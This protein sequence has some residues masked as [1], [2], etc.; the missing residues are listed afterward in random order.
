MNVD[1]SDPFTY[2]LLIQ[3]DTKKIIYIV[4]SFLALF[5][6]IYGA[7]SLTNQEPVTFYESLTKL[8][9]QDH[10]KW[11]KKSNLILFKYSDFECPACAT[12]GSLLKSFA[13]NP[14]NKDLISQVSFVYR[15]FPLDQIH[16]HARS[17]AQA[18]VAAGIQ[19]KFYE[20]HDVLF[21]KQSEWSKAP[22]PQKIFEDYA[23]ELNLDVAKFNSDSNSQTVKDKVQSDYISGLEANVQGTPSFYLNGNKISFRSEQELQ[24]IIKNEISKT[25]T[26]K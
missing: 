19:G 1:N 6:F 26:G 23:R 11:S 20:F 10:L 18:A 7:Y 3:M 22:N 25:S 17:S 16:P 8:K 21:E 15:H 12:Y 13:Q 5:G 14:D 9:T 24:D 2:N 4:G